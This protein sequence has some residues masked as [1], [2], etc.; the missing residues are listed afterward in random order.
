M[1]EDPYDYQPATATRFWKW[2]IFGWT[3]FLV[4]V[5]LGLVV[6]SGCASDRFVT[7]EQDD[8]IRKRCEQGCAIVPLPA[9]RQIERALG[10]NES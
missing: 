10:I 9:W 3:T 8:E 2:T 6:L 5:I 4:S 7:K 1:L